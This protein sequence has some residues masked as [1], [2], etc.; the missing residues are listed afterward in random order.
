MP[1]RIMCKN[2]C[3]LNWISLTSFDQLEDSQ[4][5]KSIFAIFKHSTRCPISAAAKQRMEKSWDLENSG[6]P[7]FYLDVLEDRDL[8]NKVAEHFTVE[9][10][11]PQ[12]LVVKD[13]KCIYH[14]SHTGISPATVSNHI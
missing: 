14:A 7:V 1:L 9:H 8:S 13:G 4:N 10:Q 11:S 5:N 6:V 2:Q 12:I 3:N